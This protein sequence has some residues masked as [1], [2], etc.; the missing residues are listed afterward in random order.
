MLQR[1]V[2][3]LSRLQLFDAEGNSL[4]HADQAQ[5]L[6]LAVCLSTAGLDYCS[7]LDRISSVEI[8]HLSSMNDRPITK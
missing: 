2:G 8:N 3:R 6:S 4:A 1:L 5:Q 7:P